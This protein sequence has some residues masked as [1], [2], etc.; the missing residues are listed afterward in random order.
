VRESLRILQETLNNARKHASAN[1][2]QV[3]LNLHHQWIS[4]EFHD[5]GIGFDVPA[6]L[7][8]YVDGGH[9]GLVSIREW[10]EEV[11]GEWQVISEPGQGTRVLV[12][13]PLVIH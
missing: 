8:S 4:L 1:Q 3:N 5:D 6:R 7:G 12:I 13:I 9:L 11:G 10:A 2:I